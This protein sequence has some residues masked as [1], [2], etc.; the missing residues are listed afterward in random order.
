MHVFTIAGRELRS[1]FTTTVGW[2]V[3][4]FFLLMN[5]FFWS[6]MVSYYVA[7]STDVLANPYAAAQMNYTDYLLAPY[8][9]NIG[10]VLLFVTPAI[11]MRLFS[12]E[13][14]SRTMELLF[15]S[16]VTTAEIVLGK[17]LGAVG[18]VVFMLLCTA[19]APL[20]L[21]LWGSPDWGAVATGYLYVLLVASSV[22]A[23]GMFYSAM[24]PNAVV[25]LIGGFGSSLCLWIFSWFE[26]GSGGTVR[27]VLVDLALTSHMESF[28]RGTIKL[29]DLVYYV[30]FIAFFV[31][32]THQR[33]EAYRW[34]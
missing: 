21:W 9:G 10:L 28:V 29:S 27:Q 23:F 11:S 1:L 22:L 5:G 6:F 19:F 18:F 33:V 13:L 12:D 26:E 2:L 15:T 8:F 3:L 14:K 25:A 20:S 16:P 17:F 34:R 24:T 7:Q 4:A 31:F 30:A 32:A